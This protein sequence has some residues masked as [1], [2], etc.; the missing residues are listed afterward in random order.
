MSVKNG[1][2]TY[3]WVDSDEAQANNLKNITVYITDTGE[4]YHTAG[5]R[6]LDESQ[7]PVTLEDAID[8]GY[9]PCGICNP[10]V[11]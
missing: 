3:N 8:K 11:R 4:K 7:Y 6:T 5:C 2:V 9:G 1:E 10:P